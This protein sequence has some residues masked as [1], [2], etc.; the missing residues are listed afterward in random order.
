[1]LQNKIQSA[2]GLIQDVCDNREKQNEHETIAKRNTLFFDALKLLSL[3]VKSYTTAHNYFSFTLDEENMH[4]LNKL[5][6]YAHQSISN[7]KAVNPQEFSKDVTEFT[8]NVSNI[9]KKF[10]HDR[11]DNLLSG[12]SMMMAVYSDPKRVRILISSLKK[13]EKWPLDK[14]S[15]SGFQA[16]EKEANDLLNSM[17]FDADIR[18]FLKK[19][20]NQSATVNDMT[21][22]VYNWLVKEKAASKLGL[23]IKNDVAV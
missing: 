10:F 19:V 5:M 1:M 8:G 4:K 17:E 12:L 7:K 18:E 9:W 22:Q 15:V 2:M 23:Y 13:C 3:T 16:K 20:S 6:K 14:E 21:L 11:Y